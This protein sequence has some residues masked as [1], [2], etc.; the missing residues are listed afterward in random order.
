[1][2]LKNFL[3]TYFPDYMIPVQFIPLEKLPITVNGKIDRKALPLPDT[4][5]PVLEIEYVEPQTEFEQIV[6]E[7]WSEV[8]EIDKIGIHDNFLDVGGD[9]LRGI[10]VISRLG[11][12]FELEFSINLIFQKPTIKQLAAHIEEVITNLLQE[13]E[14]ENIS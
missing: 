11:A 8:L 5:R 4:I 10:R 7:V 13:M 6:K 3:L 1:M 9:S 2:E 12:E 14:D